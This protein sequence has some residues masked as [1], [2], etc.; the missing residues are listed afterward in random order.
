MNDLTKTITRANAGDRQAQREV[1]IAI[2]QPEG[3]YA[4]LVDSIQETKK[5]AEAGSVADMATLGQFYY[6]GIGTDKN[7]RLAEH[8]LERAAAQNDAGAMYHLGQIYFAEYGD[9][10]HEARELIEKAMEFGP[11]PGVSIEDARTTL[12]TVRMMLELE[13]MTNQTIPELVLPITKITSGA[14]Q[15]IPCPVEDD[16]SIGYKNDYDSSSMVPTANNSGAND[17]FIKQ[18]KA[19]GAEL[20]EDK[21][22]LMNL[23]ADIFAEN[24]IMR[25]TMRVV[26]EDGIHVRIAQLTNEDFST[27]Q[28][29]LAQIIDSFAER[30]GMDKLRVRDAVSILAAGLGI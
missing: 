26:V 6:T 4:R 27:R 15:A 29:K 30:Y 20:Y 12:S 22:T 7:V 5:A 8:W 9:R 1:E 18:V 3:Y 17:D 14:G 19:R 11:I 28:I 24:E 21:S 2:G 10:L 25:N 13:E 23:I 16:F